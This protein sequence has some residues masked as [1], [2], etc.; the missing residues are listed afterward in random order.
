MIEHQLAPVR[1]TRRD[2]DRNMARFYRI[3]LEPTLFGEVSL[4]RNW[5]RIGT[6]GQAMI[7]TFGRIGEAVDAQEKLERM[8][9]QKGYRGQE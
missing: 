6:T 9:R 8:K 5:G 4:V 3:S 2:P 7:Q 1:L